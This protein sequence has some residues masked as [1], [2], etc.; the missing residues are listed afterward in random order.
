MRLDEDG[1]H[2][3]LKCKFVKHGW[4][5]LQLEPVRQKL[6]PKASAWEVIQE[7]L[8][9]KKDECLKAVILLW[10]W[11]DVRNKLNKGER[12]LSRDGFMAD[13]LRL[14]GELG[15]KE[16]QMLERPANVQQKWAPPPPGLLKINSDG[17]FVS[18]TLTGGRGFIIRD[19]S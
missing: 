12:G 6:L 15:H 8:N 7:I 5:D 2:C 16:K 19:H 11:W 14:M 13:V 17:A 4:L 18:D 1:G 10:R 3:F 9:L